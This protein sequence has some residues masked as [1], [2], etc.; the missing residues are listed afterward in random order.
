M[1]TLPPLAQTPST[2][3]NR[4]APLRKALFYALESEPEHL[5]S[6]RYQVVLAGKSFFHIQ[7]ISTGRVRGFRRDHNEACALAK[8][9][10][11]RI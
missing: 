3:T 6:V 10:E 9:L 1:H 5:P 7:E 8:M 2:F 4:L 11:T